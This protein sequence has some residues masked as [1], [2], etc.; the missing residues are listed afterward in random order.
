MFE[1]TVEIVKKFHI[2][3]KWTYELLTVL[4]DSY[5]AK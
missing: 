2:E 1:K 5:K 3:S 4:S